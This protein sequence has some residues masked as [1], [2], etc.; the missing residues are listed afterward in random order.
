MNGLRI[1]I[2]LDNVTCLMH[3]HWIN[4]LPQQHD[5]SVDK[6]NADGDQNETRVFDNL[7]NSDLTDQ[8]EIDTI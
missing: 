1:R 7:Q 2:H 3:L 8:T 5:D 4:D 6:N